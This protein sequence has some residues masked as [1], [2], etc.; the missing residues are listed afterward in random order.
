LMDL[1][2]IR[3]ELG[4]YDLV[5]T[6]EA[7]RRTVEWLVANPPEAGGF[8]EQLLGDPFDYAAEDALVAIA[9]DALERL[10][11]VGYAVAPTAGASYVAA[12]SRN[13]KRVP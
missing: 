13:A 12:D 11:A 10:R 2:R 6:E 9:R 4:Y 8:T 7:L 3:S 5:P 1:A